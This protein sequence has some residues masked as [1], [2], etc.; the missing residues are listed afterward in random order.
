MS[1]SDFIAVAPR[2]GRAINLERDWSSDFALTGYVM[3]ATV[4]DVLGRICSSLQEQQVLRAW[5]LTGPYGSGK[6]SFALFLAN[7]LGPTNRSGALKA[8]NILKEQD[9]GLHGAHFDRRKRDSLG[10]PG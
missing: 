10:D 5:T 4:R 2:F 3:T 6:S 1:L 8:R 9:P 7:L